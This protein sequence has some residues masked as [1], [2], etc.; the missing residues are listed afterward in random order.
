M[1]RCVYV[2]FL[3]QFIG[4]F[5][6]STADNGF[7]ENFMTVFRHIYSV[8]YPMCRTICKQNVKTTAYIND[9]CNFITRDESSMELSW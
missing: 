1:H 7:C 9:V 3:S 2:R 4:V 5:I 6:I 8:I